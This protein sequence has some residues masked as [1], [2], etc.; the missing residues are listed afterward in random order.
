MADSTFQVPI[1]KLARNVTVTVT[2]TG[3]RRWN[4]R[5]RL[6]LW[7]ISLAAFVCPV[8]VNVVADTETEAP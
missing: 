8:N 3:L 2:V 7:L 1:Q 5:M 4:A 6:S